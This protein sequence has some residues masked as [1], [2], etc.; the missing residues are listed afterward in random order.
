[1]PRI[2]IDNIPIL[3]VDYEHFRKTHWKSLSDYLINKYGKEEFTDAIEV[4]AILLDAFQYLV[5]QFRNILLAEKRFSFFLYVY[6]LHEQ[7]VKVYLKTLGGYELEGIKANEFALNRRILKLIAEQGCDIDFEWGKFPNGQEVLEMDVKIEELLYLGTWMYSIA[8]MIAYQKMVEECKKIEFD[9]DDMLVVDWQYHYGEAYK[10]L[11]PQLVEDYQKGTFDEQAVAEL[12]TAIEQ[13]FDIDYNYAGGIIFEIQR[14]HNA[15]NPTLQTIQPHVLPLNLVN[16]SKCSQATAESFYN[17][18]TIN[19]QNKLSIEDAILKPHSVRRYMF[20]PI[21]I[22]MIGGEDRALVGRE[23]FAESVMVLGT[24][25]IHW[26]AVPEEWL[27][28]KC[29]RKFVDKKAREH[30]RILE[31]KIEAILKEKG[32]LYTRN[33]KS[34]KQFSG[35]NLR[36]DNPTCGEIDYIVVNLSIKKIFIADSKYNR[37]RYEAV[38]FRMDYSNF[39]KTYESQ[40]ERKN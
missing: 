19:R 14:H 35:D 31:D 5:N 22:Y 40:L 11:F 24:N 13:C 6:W 3:T 27:S 39:I 37:V 34:F 26:N 23:K 9:E 30:D 29:F 4:E 2:K 21:L 16:Y 25:A 8:D 32:L 7:S 18:L 36:I 15:D 1:M 10:E 33:I 12:K 38:G 17:G 20:R 28:N